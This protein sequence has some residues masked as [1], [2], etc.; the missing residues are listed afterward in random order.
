[1]FNLCAAA[2]AT[3]FKYAG[4]EKVKTEFALPEATDFRPE[5]WDELAEK[6]PFM[7]TE[8]ERK[9]QERILQLKKEGQ[10]LEE[11]K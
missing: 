5:E 3:Q 9:I 4:W 8:E 7:I 6:Y 11:E 1:M 10:V 2:I